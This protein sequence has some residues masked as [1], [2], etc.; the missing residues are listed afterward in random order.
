MS[1]NRFY[2]TNS[3]SLGPQQLSLAEDW[4]PLRLLRR[5]TTVLGV[6]SGPRSGPKRNFRHNGANF[7]HFFS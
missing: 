5:Q 4:F 3:K 7:R 2:Q 1:R 6:R